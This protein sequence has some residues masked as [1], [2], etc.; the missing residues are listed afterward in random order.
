MIGPWLGF[1]IQISGGKPQLVSVEAPGF[2]RDWR[3]GVLLLSGVCHRLV[4]VPPWTQ[5]AL[6]RTTACGT[7]WG[8]LDDPLWR[9]S[10]HRGGAVTGRTVKG[11]R[12]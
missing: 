11:F 8:Q 10:L 9:P 2:R 7:Q 6:W 1:F 12:A 3:R 4:V 5:R